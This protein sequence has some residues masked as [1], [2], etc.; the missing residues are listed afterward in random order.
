MYIKHSELKH[1]EFKRTGAGVLRTFDLSLTTIKGDQNVTFVSIDKD[2]QKSLFEYFKAAGIKIKTVDLDGNRSDMKDTPAEKEN[3][4]DA[5]MAEYD[6]EDEDDGSFNENDASKNSQG[7][8]SEDDEEASED[9]FDDENESDVEMD[10]IDKDELKA[11][12]K[13]LKKEGLAEL[14]PRRAPKKE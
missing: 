3:R 12:Q 7:E 9:D 1:V 8:D 11:L 13:E 2:E 4:A 14:R 5:N 6:D 10:Q